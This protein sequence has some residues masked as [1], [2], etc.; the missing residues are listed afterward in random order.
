MKKL[1]ILL[2]LICIINIQSTAEPITYYEHVTTF[3]TTLFDQIIWFWTEDTL[4]GPIMSND[5]IGLKYSPHFY[6]QV[7]TCQDR[8][9]YRDPQNIYF[10][11]PPRFNCPPFMFEMSYQHLI[12]LANP[13]I[14]DGDGRLMTR[15]WFRGEDGIVIYQYRLGSEPPPLYGDINDLQNVR[16]L[17]PPVRQIIY[18]DG[19]CEVYGELVGR[20][21]VY[22]SGDMYLID[23]IYYEGADRRNGRF[24]E[25]DMQ[26]I[27]GLISDRNIIIRNNWYNGRENGYRRYSPQSTDHH[28]ITI[29]GSLI[30]LDGSFTFEHQNDDWEAYQGPSPDERGIIHHKGGVA[31][32]RRG[33]LHRSNHWG[34]GYRKDRNYD[35]RLLTTGPPGLD[36]NIITGNYDRLNLW[37]GPY[38]ISNAIVRTLSIHPGV[39]IRLNGINALRI[40]DSLLVVGN[41]DDPVTFRSGMGINQGHLWVQFKRG[42]FTNL[43]HTVIQSTISLHLES[44]RVNIE[45]CTINGTI[46]ASGN[47]HLANNS[48]TAPVDLSSFNRI[49]VEKNVFTGGLKIKGNVQDGRIYNNTIVNGRH[50]GLELRRF[51]NLEVINNIIAF[52]ERGIDNRHWDAPVL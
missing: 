43:Q 46:S 35:C 40:S 45:N 3:E 50:S 19:R 28:S 34:T 2:F 51:R 7:S 39:E 5:Y 1:L 17:R 15:V 24:D 30:A 33:Y 11:Y 44:E 18:I 8:F 41:E 37:Q 42:S 23:D 16:Q 47:I 32:W 49:M 20:L 14:E 12:H 6:G 36:A 26:H 4:Y 21:T 31:Q 9:I 52:N 27:L 13:I 22:S 48:F 10:A 38:N 25:D 29:N